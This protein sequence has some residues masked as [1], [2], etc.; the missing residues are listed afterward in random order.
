MRSIALFFAL[1]AALLVQSSQASVNVVPAL[2][3]N[4][5]PSPRTFCPMPLLRLENWAPVPLGTALHQEEFLHPIVEG[6]SVARVYCQPGDCLPNGPK[7]PA[8]CLMYLEYDNNRVLSS[9]SYSY[10]PGVTPGWTN[11]SGTLTASATEHSFV[12]WGYCGTTTLHGPVLEFDNS[13]FERPLVDGEPK[14]SCSTLTDS[15]TVTYTPTPTPSPNP[16]H[17]P[18]PSPLASTI[19]LTTTTPSSAPLIISLSSATTSS[20]ATPSPTPSKSPVTRSSSIPVMPPQSSNPANTFTQIPVSVLL[21]SGY[22]LCRQSGALARSLQCPLI[23]APYSGSDH[24]HFHLDWFY[25][26]FSAV[27]WVARFL[28]QHH[29]PLSIR[30]LRTEPRR[31]QLSPR[32]PLGT[33]LL[34]PLVLPIPHHFHGLQRL[35]QPLHEH[36]DCSDHAYRHNHRLSANSDRPSR[37]EHLCLN[38]DTRRVNYGGDGDSQCSCNCHRASDRKLRLCSVPRRFQRRAESSASP[39]GAESA[40]TSSSGLASGFASIPGSPSGTKLLTAPKQDSEVASGPGAIRPSPPVSGSAY[41]PTHSFS[42]FPF[43]FP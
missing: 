4:A 11:I 37:T 20:S 33:D 7:R 3:L 41:Y 16:T 35:P 31:L 40:L 29:F 36:I 13:R 9:G 12:M 10:V 27:Q 1:L 19:V 5:R 2:G 34:R 25:L 17:T 24:R 39:A 43:S 6:Q 32:S 38:R 23:L 22:R 15:S 26:Q 8:T 21:Q 18:T 14:E 28:L 42:V 30:L